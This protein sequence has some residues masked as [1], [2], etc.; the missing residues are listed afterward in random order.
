M[1]VLS[2]CDDHFSYRMSDTAI[3]SKIC[4][5]FIFEWNKYGTP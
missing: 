1:I 2:D 3:T 5:K 4:M